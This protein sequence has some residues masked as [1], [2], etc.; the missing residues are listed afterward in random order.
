MDSNQILSDNKDL[1]V[2]LVEGPKMCP[3]NKKWRMAAILKNKKSPYLLNRLTKFGTVMQLGPL[4]L[5]DH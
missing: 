3:T 2:L 1:Q 4:H 5:T